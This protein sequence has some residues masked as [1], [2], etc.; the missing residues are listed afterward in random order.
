MLLIKH[1]PDIIKPLQVN[2]SSSLIRLLLEAPVIRDG[3][4]LLSYLTNEPLLKHLIRVHFPFDI[5]LLEIL[6]SYLKL[7]SLFS[8]KNSILNL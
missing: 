7:L 2:D 4:D 6:R 1:I 5:V 8:L 3:E